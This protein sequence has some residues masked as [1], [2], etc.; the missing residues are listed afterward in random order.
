MD[1]IAYSLRFDDD[2]M[3]IIAAKIYISYAVL[4]NIVA[5]G[6]NS[7][8]GPKQTERNAEKPTVL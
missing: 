5:D 4:L 3:V 6:G 1:K 2:E 7:S 8:L